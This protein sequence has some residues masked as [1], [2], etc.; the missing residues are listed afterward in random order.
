MV[1]SATSDVVGGPTAST[2]AYRA[3]APQGLVISNSSTAATVFFQFRLNSATNDNW[4]FVVTDINPTDTAGTSEVQFNL[5]TTAR[6]FR[7]R[8]AANF[9]NLSVSNSNDTNNDV[10]LVQGAVYSV[11]FEI[12]NSADTYRVYMQSAQVPSIATRTQVFGD[13][14]TGGTFG[15]RNGPAANDLI[16]INFG[17]GSGQPVTTTFDN[18]YVDPTSFNSADPTRAALA[19]GLN[20]GANEVGASLS[21][22]NVAGVS[23][24]RQAN[25]NNLSGPAGTNVASIVAD[26]SGTAEATP[27]IVN[28]ASANTWASTGKGEENNG[29]PTNADRTLTTGYL[30]TGSSSATAVVISNI[31][32]ALTASGYDVYVYTSGGSGGRGGAYRITDPAT[33]VTYAGY[34][35]A[36]GVT[37]GASYIAAGPN[38]AGTTSAN[39][40]ANT[41]RVYAAANYLVFHGLTAPAIR[42]EASTVTPLGVA[43]SGTTFRAPIDAIQLVQSS[44]LSLRDIT[45]PGAPV[46][47]SSTNSPA[48]EISPNTVDNTTAT[49]YLNFDKLNTGITVTTGPSIVNGLS[50]TSANDSPERDPASYKLEGSNDGTTF[51]VISQG[52]VPAFTARYQRQE[53]AFANNAVY[54]TYRLTFPTVTNATAANSM[55]IS[56]IE[57]LGHRP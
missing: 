21:P 57:L 8:N 4:N 28:F 16:N 5:D 1:V 48:A 37:N 52:T 31:P 20:F 9:K 19:V 51:T 53:F 22:T 7:A 29:F 11:W 47:P 55:Q 24:A 50:L 27:I 26:A 56:E 40:P 15:F 14:G 3:L 12:N 32:P 13:D 45:A 30:D 54:S 34:V 23:G 33:N 39:N 25:W 6:N 46:F 41:N 2:A 18:I 35:Y 42:V 36:V 10:P 49:K 43:A 17:P 38:G 44:P